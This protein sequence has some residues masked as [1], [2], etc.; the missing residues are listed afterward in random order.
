M[1]KTLFLCFCLFILLCCGCKAESASCRLA[2][3]HRSGTSF[4]KVLFM[5]H[6]FVMDDYENGT[7]FYHELHPMPDFSHDVSATSPTPLV[8]VVR[9]YK[10]MLESW[11]AS[12][13]MHIQDNYARNSTRALLQYASHVAKQLSVVSRIR[14]RKTIPVF[15]V[16]IDYLSLYC[17]GVFADLLLFCGLIA[18]KSSADVQVDTFESCSFAMQHPTLTNVSNMRDLPH[19]KSYTQLVTPKQH[20]LIS[21]YLWQHTQD[22]VFWQEYIELDR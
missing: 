3:I 8:Y 7:P 5:T 18:D 2:G 16:T 22:I 11:V 6:C 20:Q 9:P 17:D 15:V 19:R 14:A 21:N 1:N 13:T 12:N 10:D 4:L